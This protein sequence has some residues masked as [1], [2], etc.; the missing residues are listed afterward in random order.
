MIY[1]NQAKASMRVNICIVLGM[2]HLLEYGEGNWLLN[3]RI[4]L[5]T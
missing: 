1:K 4:D 2:T 5:K 3:N